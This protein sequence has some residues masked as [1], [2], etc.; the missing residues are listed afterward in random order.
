MS[1]LGIETKPF[2]IEERRPVQGRASR[3]SNFEFAYSYGDPQPVQ[4]LA[5]RSLGAVTLKYRING[6]AAHSAHDLGVGRRRA[7]QAG[8]R[9]TTTRCAA[10]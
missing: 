1:A 8:R 4:V 3:A 5:K 9:A 7:L 6:G 10:S 2:Y